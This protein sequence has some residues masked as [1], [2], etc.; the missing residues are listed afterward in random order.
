MK[1]RKIKAMLIEMGITQAS[2][3]S[4]LKVHRSVVSRVV[5]RKSK[6][7]RIQEFI[8]RK[9]EINFDQLWTV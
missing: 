7:K 8:A 5:S 3:A 4:E 9:L 2:I 1:S 6:S